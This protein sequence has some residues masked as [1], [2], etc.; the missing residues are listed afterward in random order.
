M[1]S[2]PAKI[3]GI[4]SSSMEKHLNVFN[5]IISYVLLGTGMLFTIFQTLEL[6]WEIIKGFKAHFAEAGMDYVPDY[7]RNVAVLFF[8]ILLLLEILETVRV[9]KE[10][11]EI[12]VKVILIVCLIAVSRKVLVMDT[13]ESDPQA[14]IAIAILV[15]AF[16][17]SYFLVKKLEDKQGSK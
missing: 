9:F 15:L 6:G 2:H 5:R 7:F 12:K 11:H 14:E 17:V 1:D 16:S 10:A 4:T 13:H 8:N 3:A